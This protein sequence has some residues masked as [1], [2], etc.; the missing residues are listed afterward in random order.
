MLNKCAEQGLKFSNGKV[1]TVH[2]RF[3]IAF[4]LIEILNKILE[5]YIIYAV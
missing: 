4:D 5:N 3:R 1:D 2:T